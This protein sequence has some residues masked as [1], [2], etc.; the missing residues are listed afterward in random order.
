MNVISQRYSESLFDL[1]IEENKLDD[2]LN[3]MKLVDEVL[4]SDPQ[5]VQFF[6]H[7]LIKDDVKCQLIDESFKGNI[8]EYVLNF[9]KL[10][11]KKR[12]I[13]Y[14]G[15]IVKAFITLSHRHLG[16]EEGIIYSPY[17]LSTKEVQEIEQV[18]SKKE[19]KKVTLKVRLDPSL[20]GGVK[21]EVNNRIYDGSIKNKVE[22]LKKELL[23]K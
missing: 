11:V 9:L 18:M 20:V 4:E 3:D 6:S 15:E 17:Q 7:V 23:R 22:V 2:Y 16:I 10:L 5:F 14:I 12:R 21:V 19:N 8:N 13:R 1:A